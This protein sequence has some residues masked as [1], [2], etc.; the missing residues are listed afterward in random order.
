M[1][2]HWNGSI[3]DQIVNNAAE[4]AGFVENRQMRQNC[5]TKFSFQ[6]D[7]GII[8]EMEDWAEAELGNCGD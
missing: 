1:R 6:R 3:V 8:S 2:L 5:A 4:F 7:F